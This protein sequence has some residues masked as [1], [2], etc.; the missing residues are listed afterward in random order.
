MHPADDLALEQG[1]EGDRQDQ[2]NGD[3]EDL[4]H[5]PQQQAEN[6]EV[7]EELARKVDGLAQKFEH[8]Q[9]LVT[10]SVAPLPAIGAVAA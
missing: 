2:R 4:D 8:A 3:H 10:V 9:A 1:V 7:Q 5:R 6:A